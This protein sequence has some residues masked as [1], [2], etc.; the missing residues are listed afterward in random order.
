MNN[1]LRKSQKS[2]DNDG[3]YKD[4]TMKKVMEATVKHLK[5]VGI[6]LS[7]ASNGDN[8]Q[9]PPEAAKNFSPTDISFAVKQLLMKYLPP[10]HLAKVVTAKG[11]GSSTTSESS[12][13]MVD[14]VRKRP[15]FSFATL[16]Y[17]KKYNLIG[18]GNAK[19]TFACVHSLAIF[20]SEEKKQR[21]PAEPQ[22]NP[23]N[24]LCPKI[25]D[26]TALKQQPKLL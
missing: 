21:K 24:K 16:Q 4:D 17:M 15:E 19:I 2:S 11:S 3:K 14:L 26:I 22:G 13:E 10:E 12:E 6:D 25:L 9:R 20:F 7:P 5:S 1:I 18:S 23:R 8:F